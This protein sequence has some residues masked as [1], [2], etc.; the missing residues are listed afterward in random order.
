MPREP[1]VQRI[2]DAL[3]EAV[4][5]AGTTS[6]VA[7]V[8]RTLRALAGSGALRLPERLALPGSERYARRLVY[9]DPGGRFTVL[10]M[11]WGPGQGTPLH[12]HDGFRA[13]DLRAIALCCSCG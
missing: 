7:E 2:A 5:R 8:E 1:V 4:T 9:R 10:A 3:G 6:P 12:D 13:G 11:A